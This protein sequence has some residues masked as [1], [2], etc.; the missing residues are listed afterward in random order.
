MKFRQ[1]IILL[2]TV[3]LV[4]GFLAVVAAGD[5]ERARSRLSVEERVARS[6]STLK[7]E[8]GSTDEQWKALEPKLKALIEAKFELRRLTFA[9]F[10][11]LRVFLGRRSLGKAMGETKDTA[12]SQLYKLLQDESA[13]ADAIR[14]KLAE[15]RT[16]SKEER[17]KNRER[18]RELRE[19]IGKQEAKLKELLS[20]RQEALLVLRSV[21]S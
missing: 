4:L 10:G 19:Q 20:I 14:A 16:A 5:P 8:L 1:I 12:Q 9:R 17:Q 11:R 7:E 3:G 2:L 21:I 6:M 18:S 15:V 13:D